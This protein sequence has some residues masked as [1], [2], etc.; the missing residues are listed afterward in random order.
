MA[1][2]QDLVGLGVPPSQAT[3]LAFTPQAVTAAGTATGTA[4]ALDKDVSFLNV[5]TA[6]SQDGI[7]FH[8]NTPLGKPI[9]VFNLA[10]TTANVY[11]STG[12]AI[13]G[14][15]TDAAVTIAQNKVRVFM[16]YSTNVWVSWLTA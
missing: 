3:Y 1:T 15:S 5:T 11:P 2:A 10:A 12:G 4:T 6:G 14:G 8:A 16:R 9:V 7:R 13:N